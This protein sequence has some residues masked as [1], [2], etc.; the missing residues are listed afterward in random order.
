MAHLIHKR[1]LK[2]EMCWVVPWIWSCDETKASENFTQE[3]L[4]INK[5]NQM[6]ISNIFSKMAKFV[7]TTAFLSY[8]GGCFCLKIGL[9]LN[10][11]QY[12][13]FN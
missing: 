7:K 3:V 8:F 12:L 10:F 11:Y 5:F 2:E 1:L 6:N 9:K 4:S 13:L